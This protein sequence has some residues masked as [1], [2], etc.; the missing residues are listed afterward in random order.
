MKQYHVY[1]MASRS[2]T[3]YVGVTNDLASASN[4][5]ISASMQHT[6]ILSA[7]KNLLRDSEHA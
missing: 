4:H 2:K 1:V 3:L 6:V 7:A 5:A